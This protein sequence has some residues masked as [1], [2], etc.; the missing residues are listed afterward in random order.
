M[1]CSPKLSWRWRLISPTYCLPHFL[2]LITKVNKAGYI[3]QAM[4]GFERVGISLVEVYERA[5]RSVIS[6]SKKAQKVSQMYFMALKKSRIHSGFVVYSYF[7]DS[8]FTVFERDGKFWTRYVKGYHLSIAG[9]LK[10]YLFFQK[11][12]I[13][14]VGPR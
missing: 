14:G 5:G 7:K 1:R 8:K 10:W 13:K 11:G 12:Y 2:H 6:G 9:I 4:K 3:F